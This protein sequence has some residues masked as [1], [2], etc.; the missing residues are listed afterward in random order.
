[1]RIVVP[2]K[3]V[4]DI[5]SDRAFEDCRLVRD[6]S[7]GTLNEL[8]EHAVEAALSI[9]ESLDDDARAA[10]DVVVVTMAGPDADAAVRKTFQMGVDRGVRISDEGLEGSDYA[11]TARTLA[12]AVRRLGDETPVDLVITGM[13]ALDGLGS[14]VPVYLA[15]ELGLPQLTNA[16]ELDV[17]TAART[18]RV[19]RD[20]G[21]VHEVLEAPL[22][23]VVSVSDHVNQPRYPNF[24]LIMAA[25]KKP[26]EEWSL[27]DLDVAAETVGESGART[28]TS[29]AE[30]RPPRPE[31]EIVV[32]KGEGGTALADFLIRNELV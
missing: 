8:D 30:P 13:A 23:A 15:A 12:A 28:R 20:L 14:V 17:D 21:H 9:I 5:Q 24:K 16:S 2:V 3:Y 1:M 31:A 22:P 32:D 10:S 7:E 19:T 11:G 4:P 6:P 27:A 29:R 26:V 18:A 25:R